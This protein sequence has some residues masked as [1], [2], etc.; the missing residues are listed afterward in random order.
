MIRSAT[1]ADQSSSDDV[2]KRVLTGYETNSNCTSVSIDKNKYIFLD[3]VST[4]NLIFW[5]NLGKTMPTSLN[6]PAYILHYQL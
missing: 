6:G 1:Q 2:F 3:S 5:A 4:L